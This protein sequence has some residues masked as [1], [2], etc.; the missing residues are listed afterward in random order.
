MGSVL[1]G[2]KGW[3]DRC[4]S[5]LG[6][7]HH[8]ASKSEQQLSIV[9]LKG[10]P[11]ENEPGR[12]ALRMRFRDHDE[13]LHAKLRQRIDNLLSD[14]TGVPN[15]KGKRTK[16][17]PDDVQRLKSALVDAASHAS[18]WAANQP[19]PNRVKGRGRPPD[20]AVF[21]FIDD[22]M[23]ACERVGLKPGLRYD[24]GSESLPVHLFIECAPLLWGPAKNPRRLF[25][26]W[27][28]NQNTLIRTPET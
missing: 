23:R 2:T 16:L 7:E 13:R 8:V 14:P 28:R 4:V 15:G 25:E 1:R 21:I 27:Q 5:Q 22:I 3:Q 18:V 9:N 12:N 24:E 6:R 10:E 19:L 20:N 26:R 17:A 11:V